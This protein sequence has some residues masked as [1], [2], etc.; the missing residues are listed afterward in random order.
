MV[1]NK[2]NKNSRYL[3]STG[4][5][6]IGKNVQCAPIRICEIFTYL[7]QIRK[8][9]RR[10]S[11]VME[12]AHRIVNQCCKLIVAESLGFCLVIY[13][14][15]TSQPL[16][17]SF[18]PFRHWKRVH[19]TLIRYDKICQTVPA[20]SIDSFFVVSFSLKHE[21]KRKNIYTSEFDL[22]YNTHTIFYS[23]RHIFNTLTP[24][25]TV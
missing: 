17:A 24:T 7:N 3:L 18:F 19:S 16:A 2:R 10:K 13:K 21:E 11:R 20:V 9:N 22:I 23:S 15:S 8:R 25:S 14:S 6:S 5:K 1:T 4:E 12:H